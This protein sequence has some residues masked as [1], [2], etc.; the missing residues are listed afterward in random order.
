ASRDRDRGRRVR[1][2]RQGDSEEAAGGDGYQRRDAGHEG[3]AGD[4]RSGGLWGA[5][6]SGAALL[7]FFFQAEDGIRDYKVTGV[8]TCALPISGWKLHPLK[9]DLKG[10]WSLTVTGNWRL[11]FSYEQTT[12][13]ADDL[14]LIDYH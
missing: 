2:R 1:Q 10:F 4:R 6:P 8:Q 13:T 11:I 14:D 9:G 12:N 3:E 7:G 5:K